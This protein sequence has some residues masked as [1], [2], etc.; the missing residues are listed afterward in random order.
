MFKFDKKALIEL[1]KSF[2]RGLWF[3]VLGFTATFLVS[4]TTNGDLLSTVWTV[5]DVSLQ[6][7]V[8]IVAVIGF[9]AK[10]IDR[11]VHKNKNTELNGITPSLLQ[12]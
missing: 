7:G 9:A 2:L 12:G 5:G 11:Y 3:A 10:A 8:W 4:L 1:G 6:A